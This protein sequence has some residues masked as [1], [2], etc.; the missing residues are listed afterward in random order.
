MNDRPQDQELEEDLAD[1]LKEPNAPAPDAP[2]PVPAPEGE[3][4]P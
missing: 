4:K 1:D 2:D 3:A